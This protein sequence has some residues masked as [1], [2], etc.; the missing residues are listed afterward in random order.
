[1]NTYVLHARTIVQWVC[2]T[3]QCSTC[4]SV[5]T[6]TNLHNRLLDIVLQA[7]PCCVFSLQ[8]HTYELHGRFHHLQASSI[9]SRLQ[10]AALYAATSSLLPE[11]GSQQTGAEI[12]MQLVRQ[13]W[14]NQPLQPAEI[15]HL[16]SIAVMAG[17]LAPALRILTYEMEASSRQLQHLYNHT[18]AVA[19]TAVR[20]ALGCYAAPEYQQLASSKLPGDRGVSNRQLLTPLEAQRVLQTSSLGTAAS[21][22][23]SSK[24]LKKHGTVLL[25]VPP[26]PIDAADTVTDMAYLSAKHGYVVWLQTHRLLVR[27][28]HSTH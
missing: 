10:L 26:C 24:W 20:P 3:S 25:D 4:A 21:A 15:N 18:P 7:Q 8:F 13:S 27:R 16:R 11:P 22:T 19:A 28:F 2:A 17:H 9:E 1:M 5:Q 23:G 6:Y 14:S 12:A